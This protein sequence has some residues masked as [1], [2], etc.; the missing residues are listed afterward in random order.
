MD[1]LFNPEIWVALFTLTVLEI[2]LGVDNLIFI[3]I[4]S[5]KLPGPQQ[6]R[7]RR[8]GLA[9][10]RGCGDHHNPCRIATPPRC[11]GDG[12]ALA[13]SAHGPRRSVVAVGVE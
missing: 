12:P 3:S 8:L 10:D 1:W 6:R 13:L 11:S 4:L 7:A 5:A 2:V 9:L